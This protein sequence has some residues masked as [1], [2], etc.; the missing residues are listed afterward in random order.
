LVEETK[1]IQE[2]PSTLSENASESVVGDYLNNVQSEIIQEGF[3]PRLETPSLLSKSKDEHKSIEPTTVKVEEN[4][5]IQGS[6]QIR[7]II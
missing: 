2:T 5:T 3:E 6:I 4:K 7:V 1:V